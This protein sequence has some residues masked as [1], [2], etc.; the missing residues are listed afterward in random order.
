M[1]REALKGAFMPQREALLMSQL[2]G[3]APL[4]QAIINV[5]QDQAPKEDTDN[6]IIDLLLGKEAQVTDT[7]TDTET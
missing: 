1:H 7:D 2:T 4:V 3:Q 5:N 6:K